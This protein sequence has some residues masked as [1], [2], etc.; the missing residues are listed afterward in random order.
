MLSRRSTKYGCERRVRRE[1]PGQSLPGSVGNVGR[2]AELRL[3]TE[4]V[5]PSVKLCR[6]AV[7]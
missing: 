6:E 1:V 3:I 5:I 2:R 4:R 7:S